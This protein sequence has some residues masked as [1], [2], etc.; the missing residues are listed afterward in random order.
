M[1][2]DVRTWIL[3]F[4]GV[5]L[6]SADLRE[7]ALVEVFAAVGLRDGRQV[8]RLHHSLAGTHRSERIGHIYRELS[9]SV[10]SVAL[11]TEMT[12]DFGRRCAGALRRCP[13]VEGVVPWLK[14]RPPTPVYIVTAAPTDEVREV[15][16]VRGLLNHFKDVYGAPGR[17]PEL[18][19][20][21]LEIESTP[22]DR[23][24]FIGDRL[25]DWRAARDAGV[26]FWGRS[27]EAPHPFPDGTTV[28]TDFRT[29]D[30]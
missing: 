10:P 22:G 27:A 24:V 14:R 20:R 26:R 29:T 23:A 9:G 25:S 8:A 11:Q 15:L 3:D 17:K 12:E 4:D 19:R 30:N 21:I 1:K 2:E 28:I 5:I 18:I 16:L 6:E 13:A 7:T